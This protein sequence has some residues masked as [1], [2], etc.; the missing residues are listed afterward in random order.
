MRHVL[1]ASATLSALVLSGCGGSTGSNAPGL[2]ALPQINHQN[3]A[4]IKPGVAAQTL[5][6]VTDSG[7][8]TVKMYGYPDLT[9]TGEITGF[10][11]PLF[12][13]LGKKGRVFVVDYGL[14]Q[15]SE[16]A[17]ATSS[18]I[19]VLTGLTLPYQCAYDKSTGDLAVV[20]NIESS[21]E[22]IGYVAV[23]HHATGTPH[24]YYDRNAFILTGVAYDGQ[25][26]IYVDGYAGP[27]DTFYY[28]KL[29][30]P[31]STFDQITLQG[32]TPGSAGPMY[33]DAFNN[34]IDIGDFATK[35]YQIPAAT[36]NTVT[37]IVSVGVP[38]SSSNGFSVPSRK[39]VIVADAFA[40]QVLIYKYPH[41]GTAIDAIT[42]GLNMPW[43]AVVSKP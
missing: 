18:P 24:I 36:P 42:T 17:H 16:Y 5:L 22:N 40:N 35:I 6:Y 15:V 33:F 38:G 37:H 21:S 20:E 1:F 4:G 27:S 13:C 41:G 34:Y 30:A 25:G 19:K 12:M 29:D 9:Y 39:R 23:Y 10:N 43:D 3:G 14:G 26:K 32:G 31:E 28:A 2:A 8:G 7:S 11:D